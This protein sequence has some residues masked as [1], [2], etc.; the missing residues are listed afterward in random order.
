MAE[1]TWMERI[2]RLMTPELVYLGMCYLV[3]MFI[4][5]YWGYSLMDDF[6][7]DDLTI[8]V[9]GFSSALTGLV[10]EY[11]MVLQTLGAL[12]AIF[13]LVRMYRKD[14]LKRRFV[15]D[16][17]GIPAY[18]WLFLIP[19]GIF[20]SLAGNMIMNI[21]DIA[22]MSEGFQESQKLLF[23]GP[24]LVQLAGIGVIIPVCEELVYRGLI[25]MRMRQYLNVNIAMVA[26]ALIFAFVHGNLVQGIYGFLVGILFAYVYEQYGSLKA[27]MLVHISANLLSLALV[28]ADPALDSKNILISVGMIAAILALL[29]AVLI[30]RTVEAKRIYVGE[31]NQ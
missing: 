12:A 8:D 22:S 4:G 5:F 31:S 11:Y 13:F 30:D 23:S 27:P 7:S 19:A 21:S 9:Q 6:V 2:W 26:S 28:A 14:Y 29:S 20:A 18:S 15:F 10:E 24:F 16:K 17:S 1:E 3:D 25:Y